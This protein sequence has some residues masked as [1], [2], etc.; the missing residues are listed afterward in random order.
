MLSAVDF[1][2]IHHVAAHN[3]SYATV[4]EFNARK[5][6]FAQV[7]AEINQ[8]NADES[9]TWVAGHNQFST[10][11]AAEYKQIL[12]YKS[13]TNNVVSVEDATPTADSV[14]WVTAG[15]VT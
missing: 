14:N 4:E 1:S 13:W 9:N 8:I 15:A 7:D 5:A 6:I 2:F 3:L 11:T 12:G 10:W